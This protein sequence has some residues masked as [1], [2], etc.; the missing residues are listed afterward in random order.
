M[1]YREWDALN[2][3]YDL[4]YFTCQKCKLPAMNSS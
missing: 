3:K 2:T 4:S 1:Q